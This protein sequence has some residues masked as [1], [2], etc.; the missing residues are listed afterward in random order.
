MLEQDP[1]TI[2]I[3]AFVPLIASL[4]KQSGFTPQVNALIAFGVYIVA[5]I[6][7]VIYSGVELTATTAISAIAMSTITGSVAYKLFWTNLGRTSEGDQSV[8]ERLTEMTSIVK[9]AVNEREANAVVQPAISG[10]LTAEQAAEV[11]ALIQD[12][13]SKTQRPSDP[14]MVATTN[15]EGLAAAR[16]AA[17]APSR[18]RGTGGKF[19]KNQ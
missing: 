6:L 15:P 17:K 2:I 5:G 10:T 18:P 11:Q 14:I 9:P 3:Y 12:A 13:V 16:A 1:V 8:E 7:G 4:V 19:T